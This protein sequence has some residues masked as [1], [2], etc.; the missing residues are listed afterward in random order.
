MFSRLFLLFCV[1]WISVRLLRSACP[2]LQKDSLDM[3]KIV[4]DMLKI[5][6]SL[7][8]NLETIPVLTILNLPIH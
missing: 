2:F 7:Q 3:L 5:V 6:L 8:I 1:A 4:L